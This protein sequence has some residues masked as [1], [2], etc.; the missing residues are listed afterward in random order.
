MTIS[1]LKVSL[2]AGL[3][4]IFTTGLCQCD[5]LKRFTGTEPAKPAL[6]AYDLTLQ[7]T[8]AAEAKLKTSDRHFTVDAYYYGKAKP[9]NRA[10]AD[11]LNR[12][13]L[14]YDKQAFSGQ[15][16]RLH[17]SGEGIDTKLFTQIVDG[18]PYVMATIRTAT[19]AGFPDELLS[20]H[21]YVGTISDAR[22][23]P[24]VI[25]CDAQ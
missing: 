4:L 12:L 5:Q 16:R 14:G 7:L 1:L 23:L 15:S 2:I 3:G 17:M 9:E 20:C 13:D 8:P 11:E 6:Y 25:T 18:E 19:K 10:K 21:T 24:P 22:R